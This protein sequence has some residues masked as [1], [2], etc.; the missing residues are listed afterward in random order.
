M[1]QYWWSIYRLVLGS[2]KAQTTDVGGHFSRSLAKAS[3]QVNRA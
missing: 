2:N 3:W 1:N